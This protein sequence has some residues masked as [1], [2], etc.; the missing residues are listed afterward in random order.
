MYFKQ[1]PIKE[2]RKR[3]EREQLAVLEEMSVT[4]TG[5]PRYLELIDT[6]K[7]LN[8]MIPE[9]HPSID[10][11]DIIEFG[12]KGASIVTAA[13]AP[14]LII[15]SEHKFETGGYT[16]SSGTARNSINAVYDIPKNL[17]K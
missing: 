11:K 9:R 12:L 10:A 14:Y 16:L 7:A 8:S 15:K 17:N 5:S 3:I 13:L 4:K 6:Y 2:K 1:K